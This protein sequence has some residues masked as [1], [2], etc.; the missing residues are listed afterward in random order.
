M[1]SAY[2]RADGTRVAAKC[3]KDRGL[4]GKGPKVI[5]KLEKGAMKRF[6]YS[7]VRHTSTA[8]RH[9]ALRKAVKHAGRDTVV[10]RL[11]AVAVLNK[12]TNPVVSEIFARDKRWVMRTFKR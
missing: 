5:G 12:N 2:T 6:G 8:D 7:D 3:I 4:P 10:D 11:N 1:R 9:E